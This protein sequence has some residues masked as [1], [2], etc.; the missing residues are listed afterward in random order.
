MIS[1]LVNP[2]P[3]GDPYTVARQAFCAQT[4]KNLCPSKVELRKAYCPTDL[5]AVSAGEH[6]RLPRD[7][8]TELRAPRAIPFVRDLL[9]VHEV[10][11]S[12]NPHEW[13]G[14]LNNDTIVTE[15]FFSALLE[16]TDH[17][18]LIVR[19]WDIPYIPNG[20]AAYKPVRRHSHEAID[21]LFFK[22]D[23]YALWKRTFPDYVFAEEWDRGMTEWVRRYRRKAIKP[24]VL[25]NTEC[26]HA[27]HGRPWI[28]N[29]EDKCKNYNLKLLEEF[30]AEK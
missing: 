14:V 30:R 22:E 9:K 21:G 27:N 8:T 2:F 19:V 12:R 11:Y 20:E 10:N 6:Y 16:K 24:R 7:A 23:A 28:N 29:P 3:S 15:D 1:I 18:V 5:P 25:D 17:N 13:F 4:L 26:L